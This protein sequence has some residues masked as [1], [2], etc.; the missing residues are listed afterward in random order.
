MNYVTPRSSPRL[1]LDMTLENIVS[2]EKN[3]VSSEVYCPYNIILAG[4]S[5]NSGLSSN[6]ILMIEEF[7]QYIDILTQTFLNLNMYLIVINWQGRVWASISAWAVL[8]GHKK[9]LTRHLK[10]KLL[11][12][13]TRLILWDTI[14]H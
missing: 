2:S 1:Y 10:A 7:V 4:F 11:L 8:V 5:C 3:S 12:W 14:G 9:G 13:N 6:L